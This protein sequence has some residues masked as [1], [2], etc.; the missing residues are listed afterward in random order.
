MIYIN[1][2][3]SHNLPQQI[4]MHLLH[5]RDILPYIISIYCT[6]SNNGEILDGY[7]GIELV[8]VSVWKQKV[9]NYR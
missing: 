1:N 3:V 8:V 5:R 9:Y 2:H 7:I 4:M 6:R